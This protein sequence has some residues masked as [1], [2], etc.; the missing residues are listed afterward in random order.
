MGGGF[1]NGNGVP[2]N[3]FGIKDISNAVVIMI[4]VSDS[5]FTRTGDVHGR[6]LVRLGKEQAF[7]NVRDEAIK[8]VQSLK[9][10]TRFDIIHWAG[11]AQAWKPQLVPATEANKAAAIAHIQDAIDY[12]SAKPGPGKPGGTRHDY[13]LKLAFSLKP[14]TIYMLTDGNA[15]AYHPKTGGLKSI[16]PEELYKIAAEGQTT[17]P[18]KAH[19]HTIYY[20]N[21]KEKKA[22]REMLLQ[23]A[24]RNGGQFKT[25]PAKVPNE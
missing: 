18:K 5:M 1:A 22:E 12:K 17:L 10:Q 19:L 13:A 4:D 20:L 23:L 8:L 11:S 14:E 7:R 15:T 3:F 9:P 25:V 24:S 21:A 2:I 6:K 16:P